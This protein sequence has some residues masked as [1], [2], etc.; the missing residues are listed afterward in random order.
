MY[1][2]YSSQPSPTKSYATRPPPLHGFGDAAPFSTN[3]LSDSKS[4]LYRRGYQRK[5]GLPSA[6][7]AWLLDNPT[8]TGA[9]SGPSDRPS[10]R[11]IQSKPLQPKLPLQSLPSQLPLDVSKVPRAE[12]MNQGGSFRSTDMHGALDTRSI[13]AHARYAKMRWAAEQVKAATSISGHLQSPGHG[14]ISSSLP[15]SPQIHQL[16]SQAPQGQGHLVEKD[17]E[18]RLLSTTELM[19]DLRPFNE[20]LSSAG[21]RLLDIKLQTRDADS[22]SAYE[23]LNVNKQSA[24]LLNK[25]DSRSRSVALLNKPDSRSRSAALLNKPDSRSR[26]VALLNKPDSRSMATSG[27]SSKH[28]AGSKSESSGSDAKRAI[29]VAD[30][31]SRPLT[32]MDSWDSS[33]GSLP[34]AVQQPSAH[35]VT[36]HYSFPVGNQLTEI[37]EVRK[38][39]SLLMN[40]VAT[41]SRPPPS[42]AELISAAK[43][44]SAPF[45]LHTV[46]RTPAHQHLLPAPGNTTGP[47]MEI[48]RNSSPV[49]IK[50]MN[51]SASRLTSKGTGRTV[52]SAQD[53]QRILKVRPSSTDL[54]PREVAQGSRQQTNISPPPA[55]ATLR[56]QVNHGQATHGIQHHDSHMAWA[57]ETSTLR[58]TH[59]VS[60][61]DPSGSSLGL[62]LQAES[63]S[64]NVTLVRCRADRDAST[65]TE[66][67]SYLES[68]PLPSAESSPLPAAAVVDVEAHNSVQSIAF[69]DAVWATGTVHDKQQQLKEQLRAA[70]TAVAASK[71]SGD[72]VSSEHHLITSALMAAVGKH[73]RYNQSQDRG[74]SVA[75]DIKQWYAENRHTTGPPPH[76][77]TSHGPPS[78][79]PLSHGPPPSGPTSHGPPPSGPKSHGPT[80]HAPTSSG[81]PLH[82]PP[83]HGSPPNVGQW[84]TS[85][86][87]RAAELLKLLNVE[88]AS[89]A[90]ASWDSSVSKAAYSTTQYAEGHNVGMKMAAEPRG[91][92]SAKVNKSFLSASQAS[93]TKASKSQIDGLGPKA[94]LARPVTTPSASSAGLIPLNITT[95]PSTTPFPK[96]AIMDSGRQLAMQE[97]IH[98]PY[99]SHTI[100]SSARSNGTMPPPNHVYNM[101]EL[102]YAA[103]LMQRQ[104]LGK[105]P[106]P[107]GASPS[108]SPAGRPKAV[109]WASDSH[110]HHGYSS[111]W[112]GKRGSEG[113]SLKTQ[114]I[115]QD[116]SKPHALANDPHG[117][118][119]IMRSSSGG[120]SGSISLSGYSINSRSALDAESM[121]I[122]DSRQPSS[123][124]IH[125]SITLMDRSRSIVSSSRSQSR[126]MAQN[127]GG[128]KEGNIMGHKSSKHNE[129]SGQLMKPAV[130]C[131]SVNAEEV[132][133]SLW[134]NQEA[135][136]PSIIR[137]PLSVEEWNKD[138]K[139]FLMGS[140][141]MSAED[142]ASSDDLR[143]G[144]SIHS[145]GGLSTLS[146]PDG[147]EGMRYSGTLHEEPEHY[148]LTLHNERSSSRPRDPL[149]RPPKPSNFTPVAAS[150]KLVSMGSTRASDSNMQ[151]GSESQH[152]SGSSTHP[153]SDAVFRMYY[154]PEALHDD[155]GL[156]SPSTS[157]VGFKTLAPPSGVVRQDFVRSSPRVSAASSDSLQ[158]QQS[159]PA[160]RKRV[161]GDAAASTV[162]GQYACK[163]K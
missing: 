69:K 23:P 46:G 61:P 13:E 60:A 21:L 99:Y 161:H 43:M 6:G 156:L 79:G 96:Y 128:S 116:V 68:S 19:R 50:L 154:L 8:L 126:E 141:D 66:Q 145:D 5:H 36:N 41:G 58:Q 125:S 48:P 117:G 42:T 147:A 35:D 140:D 63:T 111:S 26:S 152:E 127:M 75:L 163:W 131:K 76:G 57:S 49:S 153:K 3:E 82:G 11:K 129:V 97:D 22:T 47:R 101:R 34:E 12:P 124:S 53:L 146:L 121:A 37:I 151:T 78:H 15:T 137:V 33:T 135:A 52:Q 138:H 136:Q 160:R 91:S 105:S 114:F 155:D 64:R 70:A 95:H 142:R 112:K 104:Q 107:P 143:C 132:G 120:A 38:R 98:T 84:D 80:S 40:H 102:G 130:H 18:A 144:L 24:A 162:T 92:Q 30:I 150:T 71:A 65:G 119:F 109:S 133:L 32:L 134:D 110:I 45:Q 29:P 139:E 31:K 148:V 17:P 122:R 103:R 93:S 7:P 62:M 74:S 158:S 94:S 113:A 54:R 149:G 100:H 77:P 4:W 2:S 123:S 81:S 159:S 115:R 10:L 72:S 89:A 83:L 157:V 59:D 14:E 108:R 25:P 88:P 73:Q 44:R 20:V 16:K 87:I 27:S 39:M 1:L 28:G 55:G 51:L 9:A 86:R 56:Q 106:P 85:Q 118:S 67:A 90:S